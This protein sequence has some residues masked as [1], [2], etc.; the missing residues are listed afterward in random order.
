MR[1]LK[2]KALL[3]TLTLPIW[4]M[5]AACDMIAA[6]HI[7]SDTTTSFGNGKGL[8]GSQAT[9]SM[10]GED[11]LGRLSGTVREIEEVTEATAIGQVVSVE[12]D[13]LTLEVSKNEGS[14][15][16][17]EGSMPHKKL[18]WDELTMIVGDSQ[19]RGSVAELSTSLIGQTVSVQYE[20]E[21][22]RIIEIRFIHRRK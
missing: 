17:S 13:T 4:T 20:K 15:N 12:K 22:D 19:N 2:Q 16:K 21:T 18:K 11:I 8:G 5:L 10:P 7:P 3:A 14:N 9:L 6:Q 1:N